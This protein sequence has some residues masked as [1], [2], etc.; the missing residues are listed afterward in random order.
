M[1]TVIRRV[2]HETRSRT[3]RISSWQVEVGD[4]QSISL[5]RTTRLKPEDAPPPAPQAQPSVRRYRVGVIIEVDDWEASLRSTARSCDSTS[6]SSRPATSA[7]LDF[8]LWSQPQLRA[9]AKEDN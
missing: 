1:G 3:N 7:S 6:A 9:R 4:G 5:K 2:E 8:L